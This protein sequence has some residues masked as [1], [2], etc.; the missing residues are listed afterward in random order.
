MAVHCW[1]W[2]E[3]EAE[4]MDAKHKECEMALYETK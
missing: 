1:F 2:R 4:F 3:A